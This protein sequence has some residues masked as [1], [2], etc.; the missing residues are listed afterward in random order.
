MDYPIIPC[1]LCGS[2][3]NLQRKQVGALLDDL[4]AKHPGIKAVMLAALQN[5]RPSHLLDQRLWKSLGLEA[6]RETGEAFVDAARLARPSA[7]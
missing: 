4:D 5:V 6:A 7:G 3:E 2:Q 1:N